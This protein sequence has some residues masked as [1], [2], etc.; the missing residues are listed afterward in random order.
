MSGD[1][2][3][4]EDRPAAPDDGRPAPDDTGSDWFFRDRTQEDAQT[5][6]TGEPDPDQYA[7]GPESRQGTGDYGVGPGDHGF[8]ATEFQSQTGP[9]PDA[10]AAHYFG[11][12]SRP[13]GPVDGPTQVLPPYGAAQPP[14]FGGAT[15]Y[16]APG[17]VPPLTPLPPAR[18]RHRRPATA[19]GEPA[20]AQVQDRSAAAGRRSA[21]GPGRHR[22]RLRRCASRP[23]RC[24]GGHSDGPR[25]TDGGRPVDVVGGSAEPG[26]RGAEPDRHRPGGGGGAARAP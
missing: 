1:E 26:A 5:Y 11:P 9:D 16:P 15:G 3:T 12:F 7:S 18:G 6:P 21:G 2:M 22:C 13:A 25:P 10:T 24:P 20:G 19:A 4:D 14:T 8:R 23:D 17:G